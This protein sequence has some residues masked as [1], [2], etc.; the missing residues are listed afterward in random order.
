MNVTLFSNS[1]YLI[2]HIQMN[3]ETG[4]N[5]RF[6]EK[7]TEM[8]PGPLRQLKQIAN[9]TK[10]PDISAMGVPNEPLRN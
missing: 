8:Y 2:A 4:Y 10:N 7:N 3:Y 5:R 9:F 6:S 1:P